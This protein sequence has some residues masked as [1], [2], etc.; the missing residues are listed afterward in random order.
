LEILDTVNL[1]ASTSHSLAKP[2]QNHCASLLKVSE[3]LPL[4]RAATDV[5]FGFHDFENL[6][7]LQ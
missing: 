7:G 4:I 5:I 3:I 6:F 1:N 2:L